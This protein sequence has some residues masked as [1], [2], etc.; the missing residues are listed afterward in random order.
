MSGLNMAAEGAAM[1]VA[2]NI[3]LF[4]SHTPN[5]SPNRYANECRN[6][7]VARDQGHRSLCLLRTQELANRGAPVRW[8]DLS[9]SM[10]EYIVDRGCLPHA[11]AGD[12]RTSEKGRQT[13]AT[14]L[15]NVLALIHRGIRARHT[16]AAEQQ[17]AERNRATRARQTPEQRTAFA[18]KRVATYHANPLNAIKGT[19]HLT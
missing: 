8:E 19:R 1:D 7:D 10:Q 12:L 14:W 18:N 9:E 5:K 16:P 15:S 3:L 4:L 6:S 2:K 13:P 11:G 17:R